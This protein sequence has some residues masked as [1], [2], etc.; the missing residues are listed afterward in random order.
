[1][2]DEWAKDNPN[3][4]LDRTADSERTKP[5]TIPGVDPATATDTETRFK[6]IEVDRMTGWE[7]YLDN[8]QAGPWSGTFTRE[9]A[10]ASVKWR[11]ENITRRYSYRIAPVKPYM[12]SDDEARKRHDGRTSGRHGSRGMG[13][14]NDIDCREAAGRLAREEISRRYASSREDREDA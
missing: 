10:E 11:E 3:P 4:M 14:C 12:T 9:E 6:L 13:D 7:R 5:V 1:M 2:S 8:M